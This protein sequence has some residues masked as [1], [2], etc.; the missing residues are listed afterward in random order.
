MKIIIS[1]CFSL[2]FIIPATAQLKTKAVCPDFEVDLLDG[3]VNGIK[4]DVT[5]E[6]IK[7]LLPCFTSAAG[8]TDSSKCGTNIFYKDRDIYFFTGRDYVQI[9][10]NFKG[11]LSIPLMG[12]QRKNLFNLLGHP[13]LKDDTMEAYQTNYGCLIL[14]FDAASKVKLIQFSTI[15]TEAINLCE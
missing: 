9:G 14:Y 7:L 4:P 15:G 3:K 10:P 13:K 6:R 5:H 2:L 12:A 1:F 11:K 8:E